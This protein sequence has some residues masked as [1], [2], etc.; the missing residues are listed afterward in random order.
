VAAVLTNTA[1]ANSNGTIPQSAVG[2]VLVELVGVGPGVAIFWIVAIALR[3]K[4]SS[5]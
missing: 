2:R 3:R 1:I 5:R 4:F